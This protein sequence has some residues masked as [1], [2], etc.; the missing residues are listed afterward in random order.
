MRFSYCTLWVQ[1]HDMLFLYM[2]TEVG[3]LLGEM[4]GRVEEVDLMDGRIV[5]SRFLW[6]RIQVVLTQPLVPKVYHTR[7]KEGIKATD[8]KY[9]RLPMF[10]YY[11]GHIGHDLK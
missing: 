8:V 5:G 7:I 10:C 1:L 9:E 3:K 6:V 4:I 2:T 11:C